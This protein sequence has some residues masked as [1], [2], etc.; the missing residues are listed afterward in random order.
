VPDGISVRS[1]S[2]DGQTAAGSAIVVDLDSVML[3]EPVTADPAFEAACGRPASS[4]FG[5]GSLT[6]PPGTVTMGW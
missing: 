3:G 5:A 2:T 1:S 6:R 4:R